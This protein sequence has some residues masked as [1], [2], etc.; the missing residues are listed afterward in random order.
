MKTTPHRQSLLK[1]G[2]VILVSP[3]QDLG[4]GAD[5]L[6]QQVPVLLR[7]CCVFGQDMVQVPAETGGLRVSHENEGW[8]QRM[9]WEPAWF[10]HVKFLSQFSPQVSHTFPAKR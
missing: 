7:D 8:A 3:N 4:D 6:H 2:A 10:G 1:H 9:F 5:G